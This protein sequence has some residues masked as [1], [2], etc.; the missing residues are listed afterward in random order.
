MTGIRKYTFMILFVKMSFTKLEEVEKRC[1]QAV[2]KGKVLTFHWRG[3]CLT[4][5]VMEQ[6]LQIIAK[7]AKDKDRHSKVFINWQQESLE[8]AFLRSLLRTA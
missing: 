3:G 7:T 4:K 8:L 5:A 6:L 1:C 2:K